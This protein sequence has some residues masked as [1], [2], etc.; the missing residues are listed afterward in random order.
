MVDVVDVDVVVDVGILGDV[1]VLVLMDNRQSR[2]SC[3]GVD[4]QLSTAAQQP[5]R[6]VQ[7]RGANNE[8]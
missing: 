5:Q 6:D 4:H 2:R 3:C 7:T 1:K 8:V